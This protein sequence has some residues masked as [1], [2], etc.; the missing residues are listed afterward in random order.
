MPNIILDTAGNLIN[1]ISVLQDVSYNLDGHEDKS[2]HHILE[3]K[4]E[5][6]GDSYSSREDYNV[7]IGPEQAKIMNKHFCNM[8]T[9]L[10][11]HGLSMTIPD[12][13]SIL[14]SISKRT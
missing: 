13:I 3:M 12:L 8:I 2:S 14:D 4:F 9:E 6:E 10:S 7:K 5:F 1:L 11:E